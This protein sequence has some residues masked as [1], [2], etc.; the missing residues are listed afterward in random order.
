MLSEGL[1]LRTG[2]K[3]WGQAVA[4]QQRKLNS[5]SFQQ[6]TGRDLGQPPAVLLPAPRDRKVP[7]RQDWDSGLER[8]QTLGLTEGLGD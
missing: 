8:Q 7:L 1:K 2:R 4:S 5:R 6:A 3:G